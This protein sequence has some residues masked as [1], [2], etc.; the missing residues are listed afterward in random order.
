MALTHYPHNLIAVTLE[1]EH[2]ASE[3]FQLASPGYR[4]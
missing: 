4:R 2:Y 1:S 3:R